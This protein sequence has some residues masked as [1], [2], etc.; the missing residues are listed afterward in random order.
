MMVYSK[1][2]YLRSILFCSVFVFIPLLLSS[3]TQPGSDE[4]GNA[5]ISIP[6]RPHP[7]LFIDAAGCKMAKERADR[8]PW[9]KEHFDKIMALADKALETPL[10][11][12]DE[13]GQWSHHYVCKK[14]GAGLKYRN[15]KHI[16]ERCNIEYTGWPYDQVILANIHSRNWNDIERLGLAY[17]LTGNERYA[18]K[19]RELLLAYAERYESFPIHDYQN[20]TSKKGARVFA[21]TLD[22][23]VRL[24]GVAWGYDLIYNSPCMSE[25]DRGAIEKRFL[26][27]AVDVIRRN[28]MGISNWQSWHNAAIAAVGSCLQDSA[29]LHEALYGSSGFSFQLDKSLLSDGFWYEGTPGYHFYA[30]D[31]LRWTAEAARTAGVDFWRDARFKS[32][33]DAPIAYA[34]PD[35]TLPAVNDSDPMTIRYNL[36]EIAFSRYGDKTYIPLLRSYNRKCLEALLWGVEELPSAAGSTIE[37]HTF[38]GIGAGMLRQGV[39]E[40]Q[41]CVHF[42]YGPHG[43]YHGHY[44][45]LGVILFGLGKVLAPDPARLKYGAPLQE[46][47][48]KTTLAHNTVCV[49]ERSQKPTEGALTLFHSEPGLAV[50]QATCDDAYA[51]VALSRSVILT[52]R[53]MLDVFTAESETLHTYDWVWHN[54]GKVETALKTVPVESKLGDAHGY[55]H[56]ADV[57]EARTSDTWSVTFRQSEGDLTLTMV[58]EAGT[59]LFFGNGMIYNPPVPCPMVIVR[60]KGNRATF[61]SVVEPYKNEASVAIIKVKHSTDTQRRHMAVT[62]VDDGKEDMFLVSHPQQGDKV[63]I[64]SITAHLQKDN[65]EYKK[66]IT[67]R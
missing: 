6:D 5:S 3:A 23:S 26:R 62:V 66:V 8:L 31:A 25:A 59:H 33:F 51:G 42:D 46:S 11:I 18:V 1:S 39:G 21:Q 4:I 13:G 64:P 52:E 54:V 17:A 34:F 35:G 10:E 15:G 67:V 60:R 45:K 30:L 29:M 40:E 37:S 41:L 58:G 28:D 50:A 2:L 36:Y 55:Q 56:V 48:Y 19:T 38:N 63:S 24:I 44:D 16:C 9:A 43:G 27:P 14:C 12:P 61:V 32:L 65:L 22:E 7:F 53:Y 20:K 47:W 49:D 57:S